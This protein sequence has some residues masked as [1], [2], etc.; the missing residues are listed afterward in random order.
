MID[1]INIRKIKIITGIRR[2]GKSYLLFTMFKDYL[3]SS[4]IKEQQIIEIELDKKK[5]DELKDPDKL[6]SY[7]DSKI[8]KR[9]KCFFLLMKYS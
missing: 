5:D 4:G 7:I 3:L 1:S 9:K 6:V 2:C 8:D